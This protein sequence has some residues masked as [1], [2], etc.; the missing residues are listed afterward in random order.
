MQDLNWQNYQKECTVPH[1]CQRIYTEAQCT[2]CANCTKHSQICIEW[3]GK[4]AERP[5]LQN[6]VKSSMNQPV[7]SNQDT[8][9][10]YVRVDDT[11]SSIQQHW[12]ARKFPWHRQYSRELENLLLKWNKFRYQN[13]IHQ[14]VSGN[15]EQ[16]RKT[17]K[18][19][20]KQPMSI[21]VHIA[22]NSMPWQHTVQN[23]MRWL[24]TAQNSQGNENSL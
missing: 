1:L 23:A 17:L 10:P 20:I 4:T 21:P 5:G 9:W 22:H 8:L 7:G 13:P 16:F 19:K 18:S 11:T 2:K 14:T 24:I 12:E 3:K 15:I 6:N